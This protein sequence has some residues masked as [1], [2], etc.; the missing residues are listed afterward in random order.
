MLSL[1]H[2]MAILSA[3]THDI[4]PP[5]LPARETTLDLISLVQTHEEPFVLIDENYT[6]VAANSAYA[7]AYGYTQEAVIGKKCHKVS[8]HSEMP[9]H[10]HGEQCP[11]REAFTTGRT[12]NAIHIHYDAS[13]NSERVQLKAYPLLLHNG[14]VQFLGESIRPLREKFDPIGP[15]DE[16]VG[17]SPSTRNMISELAQAAT[18]DIPVL[19]SGETGVGKELAAKFIHRHSSFCA[20][21][22]V[23]V[24]CT[25]I[26]DALFES[27]LFGHERGAF[28]GSGNLKQGLVEAANGG[29]LFF[30]ELSELPTAAQAKL[31]RFV[32]SL[33]YRRVGSN[34]VRHINCRIIAASNLNLAQRIKTNLFRADLYYRLAGM[35]IRIPSLP[36]RMADIGELA[37]TLL[38]RSTPPG[39][40]INLT[41]DAV[42]FLGQQTYPGNIR[43]LRMLMRRIAMVAPA[44]EMTAEGILPFLSSTDSQANPNGQATQ[45]KSA[46]NEG[47]PLDVMITSLSNSGLSRNA[48]AQ[49]LGVSERTVYR[50]LSKIKL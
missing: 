21:Q 48:I 37:R 32:E 36:E 16:I 24:D 33:E 10:F 3:M 50:H 42:L 35:E 47:L 9:C 38:M 25:S 34:Q 20:G 27:E 17:D 44:G 6:I 46:P 28:T 31:L 49:K 40:S 11:H 22:F 5:P 4:T 39:K 2:D 29:T 18:N 45:K 41:T 14:K 12:T 23:V 30:D 7:F 8:H 15:T 19:L 26:P 13:G 1:R 43:Q